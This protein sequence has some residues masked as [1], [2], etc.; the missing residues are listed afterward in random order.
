MKRIVV[1]ILAL[2][3]LLAFPGC[4]QEEVP[5]VPTEPEP[6]ESILWETM[7]SLTYGVMESE[8]L[9]TLPW[10]SGRAESSGRANQW[11]E[12][13]DGF[14]LGFDSQ[15]FYADKNNMFNWVPVCSKPNC[16]HPQGSPRCNGYIGVNRF[17][18]LNNSIH[19]L[20][21][22]SHFKELTRSELNDFALFSKSLNG[23]DMQFETHIELN[24]STDGSVISG[25]L[26]GPY[27]VHRRVLL[28]PDGSYSDATYC[29]DLRSSNLTIWHDK[30][31]DERSMVLSPSRSDELYGD[32]AVLHNIPER[33]YYRIEDGK[34]IATHA[35]AYVQRGDYLSGNV[36]RQFRTND[37]YYDINLETGE[38]VFLAE[39]RL[40][41]SV[42]LIVLPNCVIESTIGSA[43]HP[44]GVP[45]MM[46]IF[47]GESWLQVKLPPE[48]ENRVFTEE[49]L[50]IATVASDRVFVMVGRTVFQ[51]T[52]YQIRLDQEDLVME[53][54]YEMR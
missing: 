36:L 53:Y 47:D 4:A 38:E 35:I 3:I 2:L 45:H 41:N 54:V 31:S 27:W 43:E 5:E 9:E 15:L 6:G 11:A 7:P 10:Y 22:M 25:S 16:S 40:E 14:Y 37:G 28:N 52:L 13:K 46:A 39:P 34:P 1:S 12:T 8:K 18:L 29:Y 48:L 32:Y 24:N 19:F 42:S 30:N 33:D 44:N 26:I 50:R 17:I 51:Y 21:I 20:A 49:L 23:S